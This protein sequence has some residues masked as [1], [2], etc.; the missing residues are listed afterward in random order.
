MQLNKNPAIDRF[1]RVASYYCLPLAYAPICRDNNNRDKIKIR[2]SPI[3]LNRWLGH[4]S[5]AHATSEMFPGIPSKIVS[6]LNAA[7]GL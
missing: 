4:Q 7:N 5:H 2:T 3:R 6:V 1:P